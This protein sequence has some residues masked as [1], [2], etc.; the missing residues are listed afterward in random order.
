MAWLQQSSLRRNR[1]VRPCLLLYLH[2]VH[3]PS[4]SI[5]RLNRDFRGW[6]MCTTHCIKNPSDGC[7]ANCSVSDT[8]YDT[9]GVWKDER[10]L[11]W[12]LRRA[13]RWESCVALAKHR[14]WLRTEVTSANGVSIESFCTWCTCVN[15]ST[16]RITSETA[17]HSCGAA[18]LLGPC[19]LR[20]RLHL[21]GRSGGVRKCSRAPASSPVLDTSWVFPA[22]GHLT[23]S[24]RGFFV[25][26]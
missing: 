16:F 1:S 22:S 11:L 26:R 6:E 14:T 17:A 20:L 7:C 8:M 18:D 15:I 4:R 13:S 21:R 10:G 12:L 24:Q 2:G 9:Q 23:S 25:R 5:P 3:C 19:C